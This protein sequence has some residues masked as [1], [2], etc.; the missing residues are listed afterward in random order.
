MRLDEFANAE[1]QLELWKLVTQSVITAIE[2]QRQQQAHERATKQSAKKTQSKKRGTS[3][4]PSKAIPIPIPPPPPP[5]PTASPSSKNPEASKIKAIPP[6]VA[7]SQNYAVSQRQ[8]STQAKTPVDPVG[9]QPLARLNN[10]EKSLGHGTDKDA[11]AFHDRHSANG[12]AQ[13]P[14]GSPRVPPNADQTPPKTQGVRRY[15][16]ESN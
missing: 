12:I 10:A 7:S 2:T 13:P 14:L 6:S 1:D 3:R 9:A 16:R 4:G 5:R 11:V 15:T 8:Q